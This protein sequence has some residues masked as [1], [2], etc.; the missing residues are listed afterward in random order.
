MAGR[1]DVDVLK[2]LWAMGATYR[3]IE[4]VEFSDL[5]PEMTILRT[6]KHYWDYD[7][8]VMMLFSAL[9]IRIGKLI[10]VERLVKLAD[11]DL[12]ST[13][14]KCLLIAI[15]KILSDDGDHRYK[16]IRKKLYK[17]G[18]KMK[19]VPKLLGNPNGVKI[20]GA[21]ESLLEFGVKVKKFDFE[22]KK[23]HEHKIIFERNGWL[24]L[25]ALVGANYRADI[26]FLLSCGKAETVNQAAKIA[27]CN[28]R[29]AYRLYEYAKVFDNLDQLLSIT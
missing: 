18:M 21:E 13:D 7:D 6:L 26:L 9:K 27:G 12:I 11:T 23:L 3:G 15:S 5:D 4:S 8:V 28:S 24:K 29:A 17:S 20:W 22:D 1:D 16:L 19:K 2:G 25:R 14:E 10:H